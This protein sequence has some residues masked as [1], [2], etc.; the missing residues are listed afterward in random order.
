MDTNL[1]WKLCARET[2][3][4]EGPVRLQW[5]PVIG[6]AGYQVYRRAGEEGA[7]LLGTTEE[8]SFTDDAPPLGVS[9]CYEIVPIRETAPEPAEAPMALSAAA[10]GPNSVALS[11]PF[12]PDA[13][14]Y[15]VYRGTDP[16]AAL[17]RIGFAPQNTYTDGN[18]TAGTT[19]FY[20]VAAWSED[21]AGPL[22][23]VAAATT[24]VVP[25]PGHVTA[26][27]VSPCDILLRWGAVEGAGAYVVS[28]SRASDG[29][30]APV[31]TT[32]GTA[33]RDAALEPGTT[34]FYQISAAASGGTGAKSVTVSAETWSVVPPPAS[35][36]RARALSCRSIAVSWSPVPGAGTYLLSRSVLPDG[37]YQQIAAT[38]ET[39]YP[40]TGLL[41]NT[42]YYYRLTAVSAGVPGTEFAAASASTLPPCFA[43]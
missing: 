34:Y 31:A 7:Q 35:E 4:P 19:Y 36:V 26:Q 11:W 39:F 21:G 14:G 43:G 29:P 15:A 2:V 27:A 33:Y 8:P 37:P 28:R 17:A 20:R 42:T 1:D 12:L 41:P 18:L 38:A 25:A 13:K 40:D 6:A 24:Q 22:S 5:L 32:P 30:F 23:P 3:T 9:T 16:S 10:T